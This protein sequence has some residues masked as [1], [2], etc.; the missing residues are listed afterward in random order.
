MPPSP[1]GGEPGEGQD[2]T[3]RVKV[4]GLLG[5]DLDRVITFGPQTGQG[6]VGLA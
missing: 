3:G 5:L 2:G 4:I 6:W 1:G